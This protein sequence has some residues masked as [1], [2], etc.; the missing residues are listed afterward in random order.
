VEVARTEARE[1]YSRQRN[2]IAAVIVDDHIRPALIDFAATHHCRVADE[3]RENEID[4]V[5]LRVKAI[6]RL[7]AEC[8]RAGAQAECDGVVAGAEGHYVIRPC[9][10]GVVAVTEDDRVVRSC[11]DR[12]VA[13]AYRH[14][15]VGPGRNIV[16]PVAGLDRLVRAA[17]DNVVAVAE[18]DA[19][20]IAGAAEDNIVAVA[21]LDLV[22]GSGEDDIGLRLTVADDGQGADPRRAD[23]GLGGRLVDTFAQQLGGQV[24]RESGN[25]GTIVCLTLPSREASSDRGA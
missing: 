19:D 16:R 10:D 9:V 5:V 21:G 15:A 1:L 13:V 8:D 24:A 11:M 4:V 22:V 2:R 23:S 18:A 6:D 12:V 20:L 25:T 7:A 14:I 3:L 17:D